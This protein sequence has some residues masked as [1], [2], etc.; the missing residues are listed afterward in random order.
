MSWGQS[1]GIPYVTVFATSFR[2]PSTFTS[3]PSLDLAPC[4]PNTPAKA[5]SIC[6]CATKK[7]ALRLPPGVDFADMIPG[8]GGLD[9][10]SDVLFACMYGCWPS[11][12]AASSPACR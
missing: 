8:P 7:L 11:P 2:S 1:P 5:P 12:A 9:T 6:G 10:S 4:A 3:P